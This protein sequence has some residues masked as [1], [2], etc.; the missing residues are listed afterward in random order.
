MKKRLLHSCCGPCSTHV[1]K[2]LADKYDLTIFYFNPNIFPFEE[3]QKRLGE[4]KRYAKIK[5]IRV[6]EGEYDE[7]G[8]LAAAKGLEQEKEGGGRCK[9]CFQIRL[10]KTAQLAKLQGFDLFATTL[11]ISPH[12]NTITINEVGS[13]IAKSEN[14]EF[15]PENFKKQDGYLDSV[16][17]SKEFGLYRQDYCGCRFSKKERDV[18]H[19]IQKRKEG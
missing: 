14:I 17:L 7:E 16:R 2:A 1:I 12:K 11:S 19:E 3:Y 9:L 5:G 18:R 4:Q 8:F 10:Q 13:Q 6:I 15:L